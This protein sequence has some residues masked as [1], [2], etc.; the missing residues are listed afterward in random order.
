MSAERFVC[1]HG[2]FYQPPRENP[3]L[4]SIEVQD[5]AYPFHDWNERITEE[6]YAPNGASRI[7]NGDG[8]I[9]EIV[10]NYSRI[11][12]NFGPTLLTW[13]EAFEQETYAAILEADKLS[14]ERFSGH[15][16]AI[17]QVHGHLIMPLANR[18]DKITQVI[19]GIRD[20]E[21]RFGRKPEGMWLAETAVDLE[22]LEIMA[23]HGIKYTIF[24][25]HQAGRIREVGEE[26]WADVNGGH[27]DPSRAYQIPLPSGN[28]IAGFFYDGPISQAVAFEDLLTSGERF[29]NR[30]V[31]AFSEDREWAQLAHIATDGETYGHHHRHGEMALSYALRYIEEHGLATITNYGEFLEKFPPTHEA[32][33][34]ED[35]SWSCVHGV[36]RWRS[37]CGCNTGGRPE[38]H[39]E[40]RAPLREA[41]NWL[42]DEIAPLYEREAAK[43]LDDPWDARNDYIDVVLNRSAASVDR[44]LERHA[45]R[46]LDPSE[47]IRTLELLELQRQA[48]SM[49]TS[50]GWFF[51]ELSGIETVQ[52]IQYAG[53]AVQLGEQLF[54]TRLEAPFL[55]QLERAKSNIPQH[56]DGALIY[57]KF[58]RPAVVDLPKVAAHYAMSTLFDEDFPETVYCY[59]VDPQRFDRYES[60]RAKLAV[61]QLSLRSEITGEHGTF[62]FGVMHLGDHNLDGGVREYTSPERFETMHSEVVEAF[63]QADFPETIRLIDR[64]FGAH[65]YSLG[66]LFRDQQRE[67]TRQILDTT[68]EEAESVYRH[69]YEDH[70]PLLRFLNHAG[71]P[72]P[73]ALR[74]AAQFVMNADL[75]REFSSDDLDVEYVRSYFEETRD[76]GLHLDIEGLSF[77]LEQTLERLSAQLRDPECSPDAIQRMNEIIG[78]LE[79]LPFGVNLWTA[80]NDFYEAL[81]MNYPAMVEQAEAG[82]QAAAIWVAEFRKLGDGL[83]VM[84]T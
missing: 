54:G 42:R 49:F 20:F 46:A 40:W 32:E 5:S 15:G 79:T 24:A 82:D 50:C 80:Q 34:I 35:T 55:K 61:G 38:W 78:M 19:W 9:V 45:I 68:L 47:R 72:L 51:D 60:G 74:T 2:H 75:R 62:S 44:F 76:W 36:E 59:A 25:P 57:E 16:S 18:R 1:V 27:V 63:S 53:R 11:N 56:R 83:S 14:Q 4:E 66:T 77:V 13:M 41:L 3:W 64:H 81:H 69:L 22:T 10:N 84:V 39:Q 48:M 23:E 33:I 30:L 31:S 70:A 21:K 6:C 65:A 71:I 58:V 43:V 29:G 67:I 26:E 37:N 12:F 7:L 52:V 73:E 8:R 17:A 28:T